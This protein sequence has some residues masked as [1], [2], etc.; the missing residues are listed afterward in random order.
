MAVAE[1]PA[2]GAVEAPAK[3]GPPV[4]IIVALTAL[5]AFGAGFVVMK[6]MFSKPPAPVSTAIVIGETVPLDEFL[7][8]LAD[9]DSAHYLKTTIGLG[10]IQGK[11]A[12]EFKT[13]VPESRDAIVMVLSNKT[14]SQVRTTDGKDA[15]KSQLIGAINKAVGDK[16]VGAVYFEAFATQ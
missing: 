10:L 9:S 1:K 16:D 2:A 8:N 6:K 12:D 5:V 4:V 15:L 14:L 11:T 13:K 7:I 3:K